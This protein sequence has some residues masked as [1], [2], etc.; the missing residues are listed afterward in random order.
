MSY[1]PPPK[2]AFQGNFIPAD[3]Q[4]LHDNVFELHTGHVLMKNDA[5][6]GRAVTIEEPEPDPHDFNAIIFEHHRQW[7]YY[8]SQSDERSGVIRPYRTDLAEEDVELPY[9]ADGA[10]YDLD[11]SLAWMVPG[12]LFFVEHV[13]YAFEVDT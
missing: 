10:L 9:A 5:S 7:L 4:R 2:R 3:L 6:D 8:K 12:R 1:D 11:G 13:Q